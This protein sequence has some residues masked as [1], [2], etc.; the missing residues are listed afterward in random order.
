MSDENNI[1]EDQGATKPPR[2]RLQT[3]LYQTIYC[4][5]DTV[6]TM[7]NPNCYIIGTVAFDKL[8]PTL[9]QKLVRVRLGNLTE[10]AIYELPKDR[11]SILIYKETAEEMPPNIRLSHTDEVQSK[12]LRS[13]MN[14]DQYIIR[15]ES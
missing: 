4:R 13:S 5:E 3:T 12:A 9:E 6:E 2:E 8:I 1:I 11:G 7:K 15:A 10:P 14:L